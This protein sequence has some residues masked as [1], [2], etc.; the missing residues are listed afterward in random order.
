MI[1]GCIGAVNEPSIKKFIAFSSINQMGYLLMGVAC[2]SF[3]GTQATIIYLLIYI[4]MNV[5]FLKFLL[6]TYEIRTGQGLENISDLK[7][8]SQEQN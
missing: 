6:N 8:F 7:S 5:C 3:H 2:C 4:A 1:V